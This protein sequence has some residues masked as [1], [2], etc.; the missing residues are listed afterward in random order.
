MVIRAYKAS[1]TTSSIEKESKLLRIYRQ[2]SA[3]AGYAL[4][5]IGYWSAG[6]DKKSYVT[7][8][9]EKMT[10][11]IIRNRL[12]GTPLAN[13]DFQLFSSDVRLVRETSISSEETA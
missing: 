6:T 2:I 5:G 4:R 9:A 3:N 1:C 7:A 13:L 12:S 8:N 11:N 10:C